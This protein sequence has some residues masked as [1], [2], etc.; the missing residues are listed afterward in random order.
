MNF[1]VNV[2]QKKT[3]WQ[4]IHD[5]RVMNEERWSTLTCRSNWDFDCSSCVRRCMVDGRTAYIFCVVSP[6]VNFWCASNFVFSFIFGSPLV[7]Y[8]LTHFSGVCVINCWC[9]LLF[10]YIFRVRVVRLGRRTLMW[11]KNLEVSVLVVRQHRTVFGE[12]CAK[13]H[14]LLRCVLSLAF[15]PV[16]SFVFQLAHRDPNGSQRTTCA[17]GEPEFFVMAAS[18]RWSIGDGRCQD[19]NPKYRSGVFIFHF[20]F[21]F[22]KCKLG[23]ICFNSIH[24]VCVCFLRIFSTAKNSIVHAWNGVDAFLF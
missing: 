22:I 11:D 9:C 20:F 4:A 8:V 15:S 23:A 10:Y 2:D 13:V 21:I 12:F 16:S 24:C 1:S 5:G 17:R 3:V 19:A 6:L 18:H 7:L 14:L